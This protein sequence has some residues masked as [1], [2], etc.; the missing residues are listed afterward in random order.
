MRADVTY[1]RYSATRAAM[2]LLDAHMHVFD[3]LLADA[4]VV[5]VHSMTT[6]GQTL[7]KGFSLFA[8]HA[9]TELRVLGLRA[10][11]RLLAHVRLPHLSPACS[12]PSTSSRRRRRC[13]RPSC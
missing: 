2:H 7:Y 12:C 8:H 10:G 5:S 6:R 11:E 4:Y 13:A 9:D 1:T 3:E